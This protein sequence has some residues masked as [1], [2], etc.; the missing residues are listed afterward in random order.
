M[1]F[2]REKNF[3][4]LDDSLCFSWC[5]QDSCTGFSL[6]VSSLPDNIAAPSGL[7]FTVTPEK[8]L[9]LSYSILPNNLTFSVNSVFFGS[10]LFAAV[11][12]VLPV[13]KYCRIL[14]QYELQWQMKNACVLPSLTVCVQ[15]FSA[16]QTIPCTP[17]SYRHNRQSRCQVRLTASRKGVLRL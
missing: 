13:S 3:R 14:P 15:A 12:S 11:K 2:L 1:I 9:A 7:N 16:G 5:S 8:S 6:V 10:S 17:Q 4:E